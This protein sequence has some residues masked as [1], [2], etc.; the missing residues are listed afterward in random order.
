[1]TGAHHCTQPLFEMGGGLMT[2]YP[3]WPWTVI[4]LISTCWIAKII[5][6]SHCPHSLLE[7]LSL[8]NFQWSFLPHWSILLTLLCII[9]LLTIARPQGLSFSLYS[10]SPGNLIQACGF[11]YYFCADN[12]QI[13]ISGTDTS[14][15]PKSHIQLLRYTSLMGIWK[16]SVS[17]AWFSLFQTTYFG[18]LLPLTI[19][20]SL[21]QWLR[22]KSSFLVLSFHLAD[23]MSVTCNINPRI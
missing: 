18:F 22:S 15:T 19:V 12:S 20:I 21:F 5:G 9:L 1:M 23:S 11:E 13:C 2:F 6:L 10:Y 3:G 16:M 7:I 17:K 14:W 8:Q 4:L